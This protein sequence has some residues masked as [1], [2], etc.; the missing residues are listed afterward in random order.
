MLP[1]TVLCLSPRP[2]PPLPFGSAGNTALGPGLAVWDFHV[3]PILAHLWHPANMILLLR[4]FMLVASLESQQY[5]NAH[6]T[7]SSGPW[8]I[9]LTHT[10]RPTVRGHTHPC[11]TSL[12]AHFLRESPKGRCLTPLHA[13][14]LSGNK[15]LSAPNTR[16]VE[17]CMENTK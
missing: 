3:T 15:Y 5:W 1:S 13:G 9:L 14:P 7:V 6:W 16:H 8:N 17:V 10:T 11:T 4:Y 12:R 2:L